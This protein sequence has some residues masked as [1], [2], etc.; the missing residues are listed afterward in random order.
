MKTSFA[1]GTALLLLAVDTHP[2]FANTGAGPLAQT[3]LFAW[4]LF[5]VMVLLTL[6]GGGYAIRARL[7]GTGSPR[8]RHDVL[9]VCV[10]FAVVVCVEVV[11]MDLP[12][13]A[14][15]LLVGCPVVGIPLYRAVQLLRWGW[16][17]RARARAPKYLAA[18]NPWRLLPAGGVLLLLAIFIGYSIV[19]SPP[20]YRSDLIRS[21]ASSTSAAVKQSIVYA[22]DKDVYPTS[23]K[24]LREAGYANVL[25]KDPWGRD[26]VLSPVLTQGSKP[27]NDDD[28]YI[29]SRGPEGTGT[30]PRPFTDRDSAQGSIG[31]SSIYGS[32][33]GK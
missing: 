11:M 2:A 33:G 32:W 15:G 25:D 20:V 1:M 23:L 10:A 13:R 21:A 29:Y 3:I 17:A 8:I 5:P 19:T 12:V 6:A 30:Y 9:L 16:L 24:V 31:Y 14:F 7:R 22:N 26:Y 28:V 27:S 4:L 18:A